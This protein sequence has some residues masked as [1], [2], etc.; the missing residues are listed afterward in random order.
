MEKTLKADAELFSILNNLENLFGLN[1]DQDKVSQVYS[2]IES[3][4]TGSHILG[5]NESVT[6]KGSI[7]KSYP[8]RVKLKVDVKD[9]SY[10][11][12]EINRAFYV[13][14]AKRELFKHLIIND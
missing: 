7:H 9:A 6:I 13:L 12:L 10:S 4:E 1:L 8:K 2:K 3:N 14:K 11:K 5:Q